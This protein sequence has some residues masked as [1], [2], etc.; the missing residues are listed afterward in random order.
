MNNMNKVELNFDKNFFNSKSSN[1]NRNLRLLMLKEEDKLLSQLKKNRFISKISLTELDLYKKGSRLK[2]L[3]PQ[4]NITN[5]KILN[6]I[7]NIS[8]KIFENNSQEKEKKRKMFH[9]IL[10]I[11]KDN[12][13]N[14]NSYNY[15]LRHNS[16]NKVSF[17]KNSNLIIKT[18]KKKE[19]KYINLS[20][21]K[22]EKE[23]INLPPIN[24]FKYCVKKLKLNINNESSTNKFD[25]EQMM[26]MYKELELYNKNKFVF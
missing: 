12:N 22:E 26:N 23:K 24:R 16:L 17:P 14:Q 10:F 13:I 5:K 9:D 11:Q 21:K 25:E 1:I 2:P 20:T 15:I 6:Q 8:K 19:K 18:D 4:H 3:D 7:K